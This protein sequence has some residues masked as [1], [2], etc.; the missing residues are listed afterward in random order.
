MVVRTHAVG[1]VDAAGVVEGQ[2]DSLA[3]VAL[4]QRVP[5]LHRVQ[6][7]HGAVLPQS[8]HVFALCEILM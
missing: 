5:R 8:S 7:A 1:L 2:L 3:H 6:I 4:V